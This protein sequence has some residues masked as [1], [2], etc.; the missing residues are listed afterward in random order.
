MYLKDITDD[1]IKRSTPGKGHIYIEE[2]IDRISHKQEIETAHWLLDNFGGEI[3]VLNDYRT[4]NVKYPDYEW[5][6][7]YWELKYTTTKNSL[8]KA[9][10]KAVAQISKKPGGIIINTSL[11]NLGR[12]NGELIK[13]LSKTKIKHLLIIIKDNKSLIKILEYNKRNK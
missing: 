6:G 4:Y 12:I 7:K 2:G 1:F 10:R 13:R 3:T 9:I 5:N 11:S 8:E